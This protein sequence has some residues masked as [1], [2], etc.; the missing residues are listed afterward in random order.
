MHRVAAA[1][2]DGSANQVIE[3]LTG[4]VV[5]NA[6]VHGPEDGRVRVALRIDHRGVRVA[7]TDESHVRPQVQHPAPTAVSGRGMALVEALSRT[8]G[9]DL[10]EGAGKTVW[11]LVDPEAD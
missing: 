9:V 2:V 1:G 8:W 4:E 11:F 7:V 6:V 3:L 10:H 5:A